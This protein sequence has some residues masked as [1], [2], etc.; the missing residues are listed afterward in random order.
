MTSRQFHRQAMKVFREQET[1]GRLRALGV[2]A[3]MVRWATETQ[4]EEALRFWSDERKITARL[5]SNA[6]ARQTGGK[7]RWERAHRPPDFAEVDEV[8]CLWCGKTVGGEVEFNP[9]R[10]DSKLQAEVICHLLVEQHLFEGCEGMTDERL[11]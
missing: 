10:D 3:D 7:L 4:N 2:A 6:Y 1:G 9:R 11:S 5:F 8:I